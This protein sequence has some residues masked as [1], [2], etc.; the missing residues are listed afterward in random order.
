MTKITIIVGSTREG[1]ITDK[2]AAWV[3]NEAVKVADAEVLGVCE[4]RGFSLRT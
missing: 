1:R 4:S 2:L 3:A